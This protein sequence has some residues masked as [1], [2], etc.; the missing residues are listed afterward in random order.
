MKCF[1][2]STEGIYYRFSST[3]C[4]RILIVHNAYQK[5][6]GEDFVVKS[7]AELLRT[8]GHEVQ[9]LLYD[10]DELKGGLAKVRLS[11]SLFYNQTSAQ[12]LEEAIEGFNPDIIHVHNIFYI[13]SPS[14]FYVAKR[15][16]IPVVMTLHNY[17]LICSGALLLRSGQTCELC[18]KKTFPMAGIKHKCHKESRFQTLHLTL[19]T[20]IH[21]MLGTWKNKIDTFVVLTEFVKEKV[22]NSSLALPKDKIVVKPNFV[23]DLGF[24]PADQRGEYFLY[25]GRLSH[26]KGI[27]ILLQAIE[28]YPHLKVEIIGDGP[29]RPQV[30]ALQAKYPGVKF[31]GFQNKDFIKERLTGALALVFPSI[32][33]EGMPLTVLEAYATGTPVISSDIGN[34]N[35]LIDNGVNGLHFRTGDPQSMGERMTEFSKNRGQ[36]LHFYENARSTYEQKYSPDAGY[37]AL[38][39]LYGHVLQKKGKTIPQP[40]HQ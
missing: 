4:M 23:D 5:K 31:W 28:K 38:I 16:G 37:Q 17:R 6:G 9:E 36:Y 18:I 35:L 7:E 19:M 34:I 22:S 1:T 3:Y 32:N 8:H 33:Y 15:K 30:E 20:S 27:Q 40:V 10:N 25:V 39:K 13:A 29:M 12:L 24:S 14:V 26:E 21:K 2:A 11:L